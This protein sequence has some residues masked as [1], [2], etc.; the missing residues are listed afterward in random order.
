MNEMK[1]EQEPPLQSLICDGCVEKFHNDL[2]DPV[3]PDE[4]E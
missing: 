4:T 1:M 2:H 3:P